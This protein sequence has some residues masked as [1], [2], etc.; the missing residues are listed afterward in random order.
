MVPTAT[1]IT[2]ALLLVVSVLL[3]VVGILIVRRRT[4]VSIVSFFVGMAV[5]TVCFI[6]AIATSVLASSFIASPV[7]LT[8]VLSLRAGLVEEF[9]RFTAFKW[10]LKRRT[11]LGDGLMYGVGHGGMEVLLVF[12]LSM[13]SSLVLVLMYNFGALDALAASLPSDQFGAL[14][15]SIDQLAKTSPLLLS[16]GLVERLSALCVHIAL[17][18]IVFC[19]VRQK[20]WG[21]FVLAI[22]LHTATDA[23]TALYIAG[24]VGT[25]G[26]EAIVAGIAVCLALIAWRIARSYRPPQEVPPAPQAPL[27]PVV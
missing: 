6:I 2:L 1:I 25:W 10:L 24:Y 23:S 15:Q 16:A 17:S 4:K 19:A 8:L 9:G 14:Q 11:A 27:M 12:S 7:I 22:A 18:V 26:I 20:K 21:Y 13:F 5:F 3:P